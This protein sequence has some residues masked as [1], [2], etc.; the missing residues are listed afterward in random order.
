MMFGTRAV[1]DLYWPCGKLLSK[2]Q[3]CI[4][5]CTI[6]VMAQPNEPAGTIAG[7]LAALATALKSL[8]PNQHATNLKMP[9]FEWT[10]SDQYDE[11]KLFCESTKSWF[12][13]QAIPDEPDDKG[14]HLE[15]ILNFLGTTGHQKWNQWTP[16]NASADDI[17]ATMKSVKSFLDHLAS[18]IDHTVSQ[19]CQIYQVEDT[20]IKPGET[21]YELVDHLRALANRCNFPKDKE[22]E[23]NVQI[24]LV[25]VLTHS[26]LVKKLLALNLKATTVK[27]LKTRKTHIVIADNFNVMGLN[28]KTASA[29][30]KWSQQPQSHPQQQQPK[31]ANL[32]NQHA[33]GNCT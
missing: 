28:S 12:C 11:F 27:M 10:T 2:S 7:P 14:A 6:P 1:L 4:I 20:W 21:P 32:Q 19:R 8:M 25:H 23:W 9:T 26:E 15:Y 33:C 16:A 31:M 24:C 13:L 30:K 29:V 5:H 18:Q 22:K 3:V 17:V